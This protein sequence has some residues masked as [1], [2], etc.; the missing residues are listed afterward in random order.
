M[1][2]MGFC[3][4]WSS[5]ASQTESTCPDDITS[6]ATPT[7]TSCSDLDLADEAPQAECFCHLVYTSSDTAPHV[8]G[9]SDAVDIIADLRATAPSANIS[10]PDHVPLV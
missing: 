4:S 10:P 3:C 7:L 1:L 2:D 9:L 8:E 5:A 6:D